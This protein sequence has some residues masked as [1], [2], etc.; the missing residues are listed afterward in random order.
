[1]AKE[2]ETQHPEPSRLEAFALGRLSS[3][4]MR[5]LEAHLADCPACAR[6]VMATPD[7]PLIKSLRRV[8][9]TTRP[10]ESRR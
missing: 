6:V 9:E 8:P 5:V 7:D 3:P 4:Q 1:M 2:P 10:S